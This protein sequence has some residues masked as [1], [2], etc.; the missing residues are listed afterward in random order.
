MLNTGVKRRTWESKNA[1]DSSR[2]SGVGSS[3]NYAYLISDD[4][5]KDA[6]IIDPANPPEYVVPS[7]L[8]P[9][10]ANVSNQTTIEHQLT[11]RSE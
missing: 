8:P 2:L 3:N 1:N 7:R 11:V 4:E 6:V 5:T 9:S 10:P